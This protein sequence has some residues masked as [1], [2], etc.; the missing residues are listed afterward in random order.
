MSKK[1]FP[2]MRPVHCNKSMEKEAAR[3]LVAL[4]S[5]AEHTGRNEF[6]NIP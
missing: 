2:G 5:I 3:V 4:R 1:I 6:C